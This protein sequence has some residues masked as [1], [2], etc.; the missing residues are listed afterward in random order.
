MSLSS[1]F[2]TFQKK[3]KRTQV[4][5]RAAAVETLE[6]RTLL[7]TWY[8]APTG[9]DGAA[10]SLA[11]PMKTV[12]YALGRAQS[13]DTITLRG[14]TYSLSSEIRIEKPNITIQGYQGETAKI[15]APTTNSSIQVAVRVDVDAD[16]TKLLNLDISGGY[17]Y[18]LKTESL[19]DSGAPVE[20]GP[21]HLLVSGS[22]LHDSGADVVKL[23][24]KTDYSIIEFC[25]IYNSGRRD[26]SN[27]EGLDAVQANYSTLRDSYIHDTTTNGVYYKG[28]DVGTVIERNRVANTAHSGILL[29]QSTDENWFD[30]SN[31]SMYESIDAIVRNNIVWNTEGAGIGAWAA[32]RPQIYNNTMYNVAKSM[33]GG[34]L[35][36][37]Q[38]HWP[39]GYT[40]NDGVIV[41]STDVTLYNNIV[42]VSGSRP[43]LEVRASGLTGF[44]KSDYNYFYKTNGAASFSNDV[45]GVYGGL[46][47]WK[48]AG[49]DAHSY[50][51]N[52]GLDTANLYHL[53]SSSAAINKG[54]TLSVVSSDYDRE[55][56]P[57]GGAFDIGA[58][59]FGGVVTTPTDPIPTDPTPTDPTPT[60]PT[61]TDPT[62][63]S[64]V[65]TNTSFTTQSGTFNLDFDATPVQG[66]MDMILG[67]SNGASVNVTDMAAIVRFNTSGTI[68]ARKGSAYAA[69]QSFAYTAGAKYHFKLVVNATAKT[70]DVYVTAPGTTTAT[71]IASGYAFR[72]E[73]ASVTSLNNFATF[74]EV[75][76]ATVAAMQVSAVSTTPTT[77]TKGYVNSVLATQTGKFVLEVTAKAAQRNKSVMF[78][79]SDGVAD[80]VEDMAV[81]VR[82]NSAGQLDVRTGGTWK[83]AATLKYKASQ[84]YYFRVEVDLAARTFDVFVLDPSTGITTKLTKAYS[85]ANGA[86][87]INSF[88]KMNANGGNITTGTPTVTAV[89]TQTPTDT[90]TG[91]TVTPAPSATT[92]LALGR[93][94]T[95]SS[96]EDATLSASMVTDGSDSTR[97]SSGT[98]GTSWVM[99]DLGATY[100]LTS[101]KL[102]WEYASA[103]A[104]QVQV[105]SDGVNWTTA[106]TNA[107]APQGGWTTSSFSAT[108]RFVRVLCTAAT[109]EWG[110]SIYSMQVF[111]K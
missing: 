45:A 60:D 105:S 27:A 108:G 64:P 79:I 70:Y 18:S 88:V 9:V 63:I 78:G 75:G 37:G 48:A 34:L 29:G 50:E 71:R 1:V 86:T 41:P 57:A 33:F 14:G 93:T 82:F 42:V 43:A 83:K 26:P 92:D 4:L 44:L 76:D 17:Y 100:N 106:S 85:L 8:V 58:D 31:P 111:G 13:G 11:A 23:T 54:L 68:D 12:Q 62:V 53:T 21:Q 2:A 6:T 20:Y 107:N 95:A 51:G 47:T 104:Y 96:I 49:F 66:G 90:N 97:W 84:T 99:V 3:S 91:S 28:G 101:V 32:L 38:E 56:R 25:E 40:G 110:Y 80:A 94:A 69:D 103:A 89:S 22:K 98:T 15:V 24:P 52:P 46:S 10:G 59:E 35:V 19:V 72:S 65:W 77:T 87:K 74:N 5:A 81:A 109:T 39:V 55:A 73:Q 67:A 102:N 61:P 7:S 30:K 16:Y 36:Q